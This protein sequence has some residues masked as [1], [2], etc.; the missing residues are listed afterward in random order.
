MNDIKPSN[1]VYLASFAALLGALSMGLSLGYSSPATL[2]M[3][4]DNSTILDT[5][6]EKRGSQTSLIGSML[7]IGA[8]VGGI[9][10]EPCNKY[11]GRKKSLIAY[12]APF[13]IGW[14]IIAL[15]SNVATIVAGRLLTGF[16]CG[17]VSQTAPTYVVE[18]SPPSI[19]GMLGTCFQ[20]MVTIGILLAPIFSLFMSWQMMAV[21]CS[22]ASFCMSILMIFM[23]ETPQWLLSKDCVPEAQASLRQLRSSQ[24]NEEFEAMSNNARAGNQSGAGITF[25][26]R[27]FYK[28]MALALGLMFFQQFSGINGILFYQSKIFENAAPKL[29]ATL[30]TISVCIAQV[31]ATIIGSLL[32]DRL[33]RKVLLYSSGIGHAVAL[34]IFGYYQYRSSDPQFK[35]DK[36]YIAVASLILF[37]T[38]FS[39]G[40]GP[41][42][43]MMIPELASGKVRSTIASIST[44][45][46]WTCSYIVTASIQTIETKIGA[47]KTYWIYAIICACS[48]IFVY[49]SLPETKGRSEEQIQ[50]EILGQSNLKNQEL[51]SKKATDDDSL[52]QV[53]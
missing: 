12:G 51:A 11:L 45:F 36:G 29:D 34:V 52:Q 3:S 28:P 13:V 8:L 21:T 49:F 10:G 14:I 24:I 6:E 53:A 27:Q 48:C 39:I 26:S 40:Y 20:V 32:V 31:I 38:S 2:L 50:V 7:N 19:R 17:L 42:P 37:V 30:A 9:L 43:W 5:N 33:G 22:L 46:N 41:I 44:A 47:D 35:A 16:C 25:S 18:I 15:S 1:T 4:L 23:P